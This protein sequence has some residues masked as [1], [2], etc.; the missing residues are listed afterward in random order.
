[1][2][3]YC[4]GTGGA[5]FLKVALILGTPHLAP[6]CP[7]GDKTKTRVWDSH[8]PGANCCWCHLRDGILVYPH[9]E[10]TPELLCIGLPR[11]VV[12]GSEGEFWCYLRGESS[13]RWRFALGVKESSGVI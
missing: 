5:V 7:E 12:G 8:R 10:R 9:P 11:L 4:S 1:M 13:L 3:C 2:G 6:R